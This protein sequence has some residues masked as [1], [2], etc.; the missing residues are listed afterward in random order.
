M[1]PMLSRRCFL[2]TAAAGVASTGALFTLADNMF[3]GVSS[4]DL[5]L[6]TKIRVG[7]VYLGREHP[8]WPLSK[9]DLPA[10][11]KRYEKEMARLPGL[12][13]MAPCS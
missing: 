12:L 6:K 10:E 5:R 13:H 7:K 8:G 11:V 2:Q 4:P 9:L 3:A 1:C